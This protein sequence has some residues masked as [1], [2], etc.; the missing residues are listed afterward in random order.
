[1]STERT[2]W[3]VTEASHLADAEEGEGVRAYMRRRRLAP[4]VA[5]ALRRAEAAARLEAALRMVPSGR[6]SVLTP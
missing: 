3:G 6:W 5:E 4:L 1:M 2:V